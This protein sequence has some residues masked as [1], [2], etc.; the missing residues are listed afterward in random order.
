VFFCAGT[1]RQ[2]LQLRGGRGGGGHGGYAALRTSGSSSSEGAIVVLNAAA[3]PATIAIDLTGT[4]VVRPQTADD[5]LLPVRK[6]PL[7]SFQPFIHNIQKR[8]FYQDRLGTNTGRAEKQGALF[9]ASGEDG[10][11]YTSDGCVACAPGGSWLGRLYRQAERR[12]F[13]AMIVIVFQGACMVLE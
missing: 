11:A 2:P 8:S 6:P 4:A 12:R 5:L 10:S 7:H 1:S 13:S 9:L 3:H